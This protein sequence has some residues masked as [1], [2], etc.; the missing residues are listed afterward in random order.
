MLTFDA[1][2]KKLELF[3]DLF[4]T[5]LKFQNQLTEDNKNNHI[6]SFMTEHALQTLKNINN[7][8]WENLSEFLAIF[9]KIYVKPELMATA[10]YKIQELVFKPGNQNLVDFLDEHRE[11]AKDAFG[12]AAYIF[13]EQF[14]FAIMPRHL[15]KPKNHAQLENGTYAHS[16]RFLHTLK[17]NQ[18]WTV[19][20][21]MMSC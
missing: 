10:K 5:S 14:I 4:Q 19:C 21:L 1:N 16:N 20:K 11:L 13:F 8:N 18:S 15:Q 3:E 7:P 6:H 9:C 2:S 12:L 17:A